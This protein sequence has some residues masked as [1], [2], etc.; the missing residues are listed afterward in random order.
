MLWWR[1][2]GRRAAALSDAQQALLRRHV[3]YHAKLPEDR[4]ADL[5]RIAARLLQV[6]Y[7]EGCG[8]FEV[9]ERARVTVAGHAALLLLGRDFDCYRTLRSILIYPDVFVGRRDEPDEL[10]VIDEDGVEMEGES[11]SLGAMVLSWA[12]V[13]RD[14]ASFTGRHVILHECAHQIYDDGYLVDPDSGDDLYEALDDAHEAHV[15]RIERGRKTMIDEYGAE[16]PAEFFSVATESFFE[17]PVAMATRQPELYD[18]LRR[19]YV[20]DPQAYFLRQ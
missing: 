12:D 16:N 17:R 20:Q 9:D 8:G 13:V 18:L 2:R 6:K 14:S 1:R 3:P 15:D 5:E 10:G 11:W 4:R 19:I 7:F